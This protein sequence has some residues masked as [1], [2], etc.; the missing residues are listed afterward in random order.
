VNVLQVDV[1]LSYT[2]GYRPARATVV[3][4]TG[5]IETLSE[6]QL[7]AVLAHELA[8]VKNRDAILT[9]LLSLEYVLPKYF[10]RAINDMLNREQSSA[11]RA[12]EI[13]FV[14]GG[15][16]WFA[17]LVLL[18]LTLT[19]LLSPILVPNYFLHRSFARAREYAAD[20]GAAALTGNPTLVAN[21]IRTLDAELAEPPREDLRLSVS[22]SSM[23]IL[24]ITE[25]TYTKFSK[26]HPPTSKR[27]ANL[28][29]LERALET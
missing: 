11:G 25:A 27:L 8:H 14:L 20:R 12:L 29:A 17:F 21:T 2:Y 28:Q 13:A 7:E 16:V 1:P 22:T 23:S 4:S 6:E 9:S 3:L 18:V 19:L 24:P 5:L 15:P 10:H 26:T